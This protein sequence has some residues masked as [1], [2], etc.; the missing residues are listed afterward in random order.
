MTKIIIFLLLLCFLVK[1]TDEFGSDDSAAQPINIQSRVWQAG[2]SAELASR[3]KCWIDGECKNGPSWWLGSHDDSEHAYRSRTSTY[4][5]SLSY[6]SNSLCHR[7]LGVGVNESACLG[8]AAQRFHECGNTEA[9][10]I[11]ATFVPSGATA[12]HP[13][14][15]GT[16]PAPRAR[17]IAPCPLRAC[18]TPRDPSPMLTRMLLSPHGTDPCRTLPRKLAATPDSDS[19]TRIP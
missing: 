3:G 7:Q 17:A 6:R 9:D 11:L 15:A 2:G 1:K 14:L 10:R 4:R 8:R 5:C 12:F 13:P 16:L 18:A 19:M